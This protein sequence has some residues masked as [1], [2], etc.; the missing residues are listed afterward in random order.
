MRGAILQDLS[1]FCNKAEYT[2]LYS[3]QL[4][5]RDF[6]GQENIEQNH[7]IGSSL[8]GFTALIQLKSIYLFDG[9]SF[10]FSSS[11]GILCTVHCTA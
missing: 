10:A 9:I 11:C 1:A 6:H 8:S 4:H 7:S 5:S 2:M 3:Y